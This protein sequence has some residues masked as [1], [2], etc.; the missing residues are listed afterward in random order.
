MASCKGQL[1]VVVVGAGLAGLTAACY[2]ARGGAR[3]TVF[4][5]ASTIG[6]RA[7]TQHHDGY[8]LNRGIH[9]L[10]TGGAATAVLADLAIRYTGGSPK[11]IH[12]LRGGTFYTAPVGPISLFSTRLLTFADKLALMKLF[13]VIP[14]LKAEEFR[15]MSVQEWLDRNAHRPRVHELMASNARTLVY[16]A[17]LDLVSAEV[18]V[19]KTQL[20][21]KNPVVYIDGG[22]ETLVDGLRKA[23]EAAG[24]HIQTGS[25][26]AAV[27]IENG[28]AHGIR[29]TDGSTRPASAVIIATSPRD[30]L[31]LLNNGDSEPLRAVVERLVP[32]HVACL[33]VVLSRLPNRQHTVVQDLERPRFLSTQSLY[34]R[35]APEGGAIIC[36]FKQLDP[37]R[38]G[39]PREDERD[40]EQ[41]LDI[42]QPGWREVLIKRQYLPRIEAIGM[43]PTAKAGGYA[44]RPHFGVPGVADLYLAGDWIGEGFL[45]DPCMGSARQIAE[46]LLAG[47]ARCRTV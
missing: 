9:A 10:Y 15:H 33:D 39:D 1:D 46:T 19:V 34:S 31:K 13:L 45:A 32:A 4:E 2:L 12:A 23:V 36:T 24:G 43:L 38:L 47:G 22:F 37:R 28:R 21:L 25:P 6:G 29:F 18:F 16:S 14:G 3:V 27:E 11:V 42:S 17:A 7:S 5:K 44:G 26:V 30:A 20:A 8:R 35:I 41:L 40:L